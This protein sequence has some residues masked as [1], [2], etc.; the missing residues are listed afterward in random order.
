MKLYSLLKNKR[1]IS[2]AFT[3]LL[4]CTFIT[5]AS[6][7]ILAFGGFFYSQ[8]TFA[9]PTTTKTQPSIS[10]ISVSQATTNQS[11][12]PTKINL[13]NLKEGLNIRTISLQNKKSN[14]NIALKNS[15]AE[16]LVGTPMEKMI[17]PISQQDK[18]IAIPRERERENG[19]ER[20]KERDRERER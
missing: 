9:K 12:S 1:L 19:R 15:L 18:S 16:I 17:E 14:E 11:K 7:T 5:H 13:A 8:I 2:T 3:F 10:K 20:E 4:S 6:P